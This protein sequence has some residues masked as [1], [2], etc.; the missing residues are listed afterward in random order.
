M[1]GQP[2]FLPDLLRTNGQITSLSTMLAIG[3]L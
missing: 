3:V 1:N 2:Y